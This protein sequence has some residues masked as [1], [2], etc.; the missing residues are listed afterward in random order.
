MLDSTAHCIRNMHLHMSSPIDS[1]F[2]CPVLIGREPQLALLDRQ[3]ARA[4][5]GQGQVAL[6][7]GEAGVGKSRLVAEAKTR[8]IAQGFTVLQ[9]R[10]FEPDRALP[11]APL[12]DLLRSYMAALASDAMAQALGPMAPQLASLLPEL[13]PTIPDLAPL[14]ALDPE[15]E[16]RRITQALVQFFSQRA[17]TQPL[18]LVVEDLHWSDDASLDTL[19]ILARRTSIPILLLL[20]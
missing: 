6:I 14:P 8:A 17:A 13:L 7:A 9:G 1:P 10:C 4:A 16:R 5:D 12:C 3:I 2:I 18:L 11:Y 19:L 20:T 15:Q